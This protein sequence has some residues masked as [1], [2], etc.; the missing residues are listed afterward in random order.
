MV[1]TN[2][3]RRNHHTETKTGQSFGQG[4]DS[5]LVSMCNVSVF[6]S[7]IR[8][9]VSKNKK[10]AVEINLKGH[11]LWERVWGRDG[12]RGGRGESSQDSQKLRGSN[13]GRQAGVMQQ[14]HRALASREWVISCQTGKSKQRRLI[15]S[16]SERG[17]ICESVEM[18]CIRREEVSCNP[19]WTKCV[20]TFTL[21]S[22][23]YF[24]LS[25]KSWTGNFK[26]TV[27][28]PG[29]TKYCYGAPEPGRCTQSQN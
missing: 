4:Q 5:H 12:D 16:S 10:D 22:W 6:T 7:Q 3:K 14:E 27:S 9:H 11:Y 20:R 8:W 29:M 28:S 1:R 21:C 17:I 2:K 24:L 18:C 15:V 25:G 13:T 23:W 19:I 26:V